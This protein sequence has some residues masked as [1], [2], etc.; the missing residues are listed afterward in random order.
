MNF[1][2]K[3]HRPCVNL[4]FNWWHDLRSALGVYA[5]ETGCQAGAGPSTA[6]LG[7][8]TDVFSFLSGL[9]DG[10]RLWGLRTRSGSPF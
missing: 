8:S 9:T 10:R 7:R 2:F 5:V 4:T 6:K 3:I 1:N